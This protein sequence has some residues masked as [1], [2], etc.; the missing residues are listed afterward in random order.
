MIIVWLALL[1]ATIVV[2]LMIALTYAIA[3]RKPPDTRTLAFWALRLWIVNVIVDLLLL[4]LTMPALTGPYW[5]GQWLLWPLLLTGIIAIF[6]GSLA[7]IRSSLDT[8]T[9]SLNDGT[10]PFQ[11]GQLGRTELVILPRCLRSS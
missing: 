5:G 8:F 7:N 6:G 9:E 2:A 4:Y 1:G 3:R 10:P 11:F